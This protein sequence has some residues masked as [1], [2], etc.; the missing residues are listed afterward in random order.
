MSQLQRL[1]NADEGIKEWVNKLDK[2]N[3]GSAD[4]MADDITHLE[5]EIQRLDRHE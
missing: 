2:K 1:E 4:S 3:K 5:T